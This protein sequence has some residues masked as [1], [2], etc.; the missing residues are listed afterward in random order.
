MKNSSDPNIKFIG[1]KNTKHYV[2]HFSSYTTPQHLY[3]TSI[4]SKMKA[5]AVIQSKQKQ[6]RNSQP[7][8]TWPTVSDMYIKSAI[9]NYSGKF[10]QDNA[11]YIE[12]QYVN[13][14]VEWSDKVIVYFTVN[15]KVY[16]KSATRMRDFVPTGATISTVDIETEVMIKIK[17]QLKL[18]DVPQKM[19]TK[20]WEHVVYVIAQIIDAKNMY[21]YW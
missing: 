2:H 9:R 5:L 14:I 1:H 10:C 4:E 6:E 17:Q 21:I 3:N 12:Q 13:K 18:T 7:V 16:Q 8:Y 11:I 15:E 20:T 19:L